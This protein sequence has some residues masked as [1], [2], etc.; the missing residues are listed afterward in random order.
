MV[1]PIQAEPVMGGASEMPIEVN[2]NAEDEAQSERSS[3]RHVCLRLRPFVLL[4]ENHRLPKLYLVALGVHD[5]GELSIFVRLGPLHDFNSGGAE[6]V[7][8]FDQVVDA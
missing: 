8:Q 7:E 3:S 6:L 5:P 1:R 4:V 2:G